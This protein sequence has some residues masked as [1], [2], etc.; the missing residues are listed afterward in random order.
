MNDLLDQFKKRMKIS[1]NIEDDTLLN[2]L[3]ASVEDIK[4]KCGNFDVSVHTRA[5]E[6]VLERSRYVYNDSVEF[7]DDN[8]VSAIL[9][10]NIELST[11]TSSVEG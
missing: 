6:L 3:N 10:L 8:F 11:T 1:H 5:R 4:I 7:F 9:S 2:I